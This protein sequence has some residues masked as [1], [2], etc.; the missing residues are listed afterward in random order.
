MQTI[1][2]VEKPTIDDYIETD[3][4]TRQAALTKISKS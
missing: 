4:S 2:F 3:K 1:P